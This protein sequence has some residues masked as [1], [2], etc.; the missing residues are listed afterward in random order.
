MPDKATQYLEANDNADLYAE[1]L[2][3]RLEQK[4]LEDIDDL[5][6]SV[7]RRDDE[8]WTDLGVNPELIVGDYEQEDIENRNLDWTLGLAGISAASQTQFFLENREETLIKPLAYREQVV[9]T[10]A[11]ASTQLIQAGK[12]TIEI[13][14]PEKFQA[15]QARFVKEFSF[16]SELSDV[17]LYNALRDYR[18]LRPPD[19]LIADATGYVSRITNYRPGST[20]FKA[21]I[22]RLIEVDSRNIKYMNRRTVERVHTYR[23]ADGDYNTKMVWIGEP[24]PTNCAY[25]PPLF[26]VVKTY[27]D[28]LEDGMPG[29][30]VCAGGDRCKCHLAAA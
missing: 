27:G 6:N 2:I 20:Q 3:D 21:E 22:A 7:E 11:I 18:A 17:D 13:V 30:D 15:L 28:W 25:C 5:F 10:I 23:E 26:G 19:Q 29:S 4:A 16:L 9:G 1:S 8:L 12:R 24:S 14:T